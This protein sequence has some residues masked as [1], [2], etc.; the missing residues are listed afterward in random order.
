MI[1]LGSD[2]KGLNLNG[3]ISKVLIGD[4]LVWNNVSQ[5]KLILLKEGI[6]P[7]NI[8]KDWTFKADQTMTIV[9]EPLVK[10]TIACEIYE[11]RRYRKMET[12]DSKF[13]I[14]VDRNQEARVYYMRD[15]GQARVYKL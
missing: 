1:K 6:C 10:Q 15:S 14:T 8:S 5:P 3:A 2:I 12:G 9:I 4:K 7:N 11:G 13:E